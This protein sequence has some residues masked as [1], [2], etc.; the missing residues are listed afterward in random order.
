VTVL[1]LTKAYHHN[2]MW[3]TA[4]TTGCFNTAGQ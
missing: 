1:V 4:G 3:D 2:S